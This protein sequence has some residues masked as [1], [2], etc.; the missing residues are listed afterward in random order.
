MYTNPSSLVTI[1]SSASSYDSISN[2]IVKRTLPSS[3]VSK[4]SSL[5]A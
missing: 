5:E 3:L 4:I 2:S 1:I